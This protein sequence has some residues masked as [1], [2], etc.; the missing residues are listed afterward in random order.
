LHLDDNLIFVSI[1]AYR[2]PQLLP[3]LRDCI[4]K[5]SNPA[6][7]RFGVCWQRD[8]ED[9]SLPF[10][11]DTRFR[12]LDVNWRESKGACW[13]RAEVM[14][15][16]QGE[17]WFLQVDSHCRFADAWDAVLLRT[18]TETGS[19]KPILSTYAS[20][21]TPGDTEILQDGP[22]QMVF[23]QFTPDGIPQ[24]RAGAFP[25]GRASKEPL[26]A[27]FLAAGFLFAPGRFVEEVPYDPELYFMG[28]ESAMTVRAFTHGYDLFHPA[29]TIIWHDYI[30]ADARKHWG[31]HSDAANVSTPWGKLDETSRRKVGLLLSGEPVESF[32]L[33]HVR[34]LSEYEAYAGLSFRYRKAQAYTLRG[35]EPPN[36]DAAA[37][38][39]DK[40]YPWIATIRFT[41]EQVPEGSL[42]DPMLWSL[43]I[44][45]REGFEVCH[46]DIGPKELAPLAGAAGELAI[47]CEFPSDT[48]P[49]H[50]TLW[51]LNRSGQ[52]LRKFGGQLSDEDFA[53]LSDD[54]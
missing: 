52:W 6:R 12:M 23:Q 1:A 3:T 37:D 36:P 21:F 4:R 45:D 32:G 31:D 20:P 14:K 7:L 42:A 8:V 11:D 49:A 25:P 2:D 29:E 16:W 39:P 40:I 53:I 28:E 24:L 33:G 17:D 47:I 38:W 34:A 35:G 48:I 26:R 41:R 9:P 13:A 19:D 44:L 15:L 10:G 46:R 18:M 27:R 30:R 51:P 5:A 50:W 54:D 22:L 43:S